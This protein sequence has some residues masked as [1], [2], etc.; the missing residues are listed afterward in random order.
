MENELST[1]QIQ[2]TN[3]GSAVLNYLPSLI[4]GIVIF[5]IGRWLAK[6]V[7]KL[8]TQFGE[9]IGFDGIIVSH[10]CYW[11]PETPGSNQGTIK[12]VES[13]LKRP[14]ISIPA[15]KNALGEM[16]FS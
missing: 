12:P 15:F 1:I 10:Q 2:L 13:A 16:P 3:F 8:L 9:R 7:V 11:V 4:G 5:F 14:V 6:L